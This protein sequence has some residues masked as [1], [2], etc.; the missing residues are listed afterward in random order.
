[1]YIEF[2]TN[3]PYGRV[4]CTFSHFLIQYFIFAQVQILV[5]DFWI[6]EAIIKVNIILYAAYRHRTWLT[7]AQAPLDLSIS[8]HKAIVYCLSELGLIVLAHV[9][10][11]RG[12]IWVEFSYFAIVYGYPSLHDVWFLFPES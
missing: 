4:I 1:M 7:M 3:T 9:H 11:S 2:A 10:F 12:T 6:F 5:I 8:M